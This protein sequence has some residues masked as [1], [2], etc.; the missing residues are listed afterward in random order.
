MTWCRQPFVARILSCAF[1]L[2]NKVVSAFKLNEFPCFDLKPS[3]ISF[4]VYFPIVCVFFVQIFTLPV[5]VTRQCLKESQNLYAGRRRWNVV[6]R[7]SSLTIVLAVL[8]STPQRSYPLF[9]FAASE[10]ST[11]HLFLVSWPPQ[12][13]DVSKRQQ[14][15][16]PDWKQNL[17]WFGKSICC[18]V[19]NQI[20]RPINT[21]Q[22]ITS[23]LDAPG[24]MERDKK[25]NCWLQSA[26]SA[27]IFITHRL[28]QQ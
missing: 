18:I 15:V 24:S 28:K 5:L 14:H 6:R 9:F 19:Q 23:F 16:D 26:W 10:N 25:L 3:A 20:Q 22:K 7:P 4:F 13:N 1:V 11:W 2:I 21:F 17:L 12:N 8:M 27:N